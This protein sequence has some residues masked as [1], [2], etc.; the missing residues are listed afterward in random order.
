MQFLVLAHDGV[1]ADAPARRQRV[2]AEHLAAVGRLKGRGNFILGGAILNAQ[3]QM[4][5]S[6][7]LFEFP[8]RAQLDAYLARDPYVTGNVWQRI[9]VQPFRVAEVMPLP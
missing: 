8:D 1:D 9:E 5:G 7:V 3:G 6:A 4:I 2:R